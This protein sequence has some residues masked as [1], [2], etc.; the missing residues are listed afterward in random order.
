MGVSSWSL[1]SRFFLEWSKSIDDFSRFR[2][3]AA[4]KQAGWRGGK[5]VPQLLQIV[6]AGPR[7]L[8]APFL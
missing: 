6:R 4:A 8:D 2:D 3:A 5:L 7:T 1:P